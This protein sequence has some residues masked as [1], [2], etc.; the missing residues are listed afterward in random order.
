MSALRARLAD[1]LAEA[2][3]RTLALLDP[4]PPADQARQI[5]QLMSPLSWDLGHVAHFE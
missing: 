3:A 2:R 5:S 1:G 4:V